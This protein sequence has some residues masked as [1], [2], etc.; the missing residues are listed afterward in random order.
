[1][2]PLRLGD[3]ESVAKVA[4][5]DAPDAEAAQRGNV[6]GTR[7]TEV[8]TAKQDAVTNATPVSGLVSPQGPKVRDVLEGLCGWI[9][10]RCH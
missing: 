9:S 10:K 4:V 8:V 2:L 3:A 6:V 5:E 1:M 7:A